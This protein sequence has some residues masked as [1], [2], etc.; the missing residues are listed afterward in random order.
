MQN[1]NATRAKARAKANPKAS[2]AKAA[3][4]RERQADL[5]AMEV[6]KMRRE[7]VTVP[8]IA[9]S[10]GVTHRTVYNL[11]KREC[12]PPAQQSFLDHR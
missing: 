9:H 3:A 7:G 11:L 5:R 1:I 8:N 2:S 10:L 6:Q 12:K 4:A